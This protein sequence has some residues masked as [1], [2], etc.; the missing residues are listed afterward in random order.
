MRPLSTD[1]AVLIFV[2][3]IIIFV[4][5]YW[6]EGGGGPAVA[7]QV[8]APTLL[9]AEGHGRAFGIAGAFVGALL[10]VMS[11]VWALYKF[12]VLFV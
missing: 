11:L 9:G 2:L 3:I 10:A 7:A 8:G 1:R 6:V 4:G 5:G 12:K